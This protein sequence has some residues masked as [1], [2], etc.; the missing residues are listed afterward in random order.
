MEKRQKGAKKYSGILLIVVV[1][2]IVLVGLIIYNRNSVREETGKGTETAAK[3]EKAE[4]MP[5][6]TV[7]RGAASVTP[8]LT[9]TQAVQSDVQ[10]ADEQGAVT[11]TEEEEMDTED[12]GLTFPYTISE[13]KLKIDS[14]FQFTGPNPDCKDEEG[15]DISSIQLTNKSQKYL[16][17]ADIT[18]N[19]ADG[20]EYHFHIEDLPAGKII[21]AF[22]TQNQSYDGKSGVADIDADVIYAESASL[23]EEA[24]ATSVEEDGLHLSN[25]SG[26]SL[27]NITVKYHCDMDDMYYGGLCYAGTVE[28]LA[29]GETT[30]LDTSECYMGE[31]AVVNIT[32]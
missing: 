27:S 29:P 23:K 18:V 15:E 6:E 13:K 10:N 14:L 2:L 7:S 20:T 31:A 11:D 21:L 3:G 26:E 30:V 17:S 28:S 5:G 32:Y 25:I 22:D 24:I 16:E 19:L 1:L 12:I 4:E 9:D 8:E